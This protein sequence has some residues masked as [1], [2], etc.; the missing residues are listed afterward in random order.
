V[1]S[2]NDHNEPTEHNEQSTADTEI[3]ERR[4]LTDGAIV[5]HR[6]YCWPQ[7]VEAST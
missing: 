4:S 1:S 3:I 5:L 2:D 6:L 7:P